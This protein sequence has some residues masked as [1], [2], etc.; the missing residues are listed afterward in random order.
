MSNPSASE[1]K[2]YVAWV[3]LHQ[4]DQYVL[5]CTAENE[6]ALWADENGRVPVLG[7]S[8]GVRQLARQLRVALQEEEPLC[9]DLDRAW[10]WIAAPHQEVPCAACLTAW[11]LFDDL[12][13][14]VR[15]EFLG[16]RRGP[17]RNRVFDKLYDCSG[18]WR[19]SPAEARQDR[20]WRKE[21]RNTL[22]RVLRQGFRLWAKYVYPAPNPA[23]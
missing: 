21:E 5:W 4:R 8:N 10:A 15:A 22:R 6:D 16:W 23:A 19:I 1:W 9:Q 3:R 18:F 17:V 7:S 2:Y 11:N 12:A 14:G 20:H 13:N